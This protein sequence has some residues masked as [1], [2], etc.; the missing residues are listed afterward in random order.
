MNCKKCRFVHQKFKVPDHVVSADRFS[1]DPDK[2][3]AVSDFP[4]PR[5][6]GDLHSFVGLSSYFLRFIR[7]FA[8]IGAP[9]A[10]LL[11]KYTSF[12]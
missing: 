12:K 3:K 10:S 6:V 4:V 2:G 5:T 9:L 1:A 8:T 7:A 11:S